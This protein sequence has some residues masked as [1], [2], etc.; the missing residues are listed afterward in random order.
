M[1][2]KENKTAIRSKLAIKENLLS[3][4]ANNEKI[5]DISITELAELSKVSRTTFYR[6]YNN[7]MDVA[8]DIENDVIKTVADIWDSAKLEENALETFLLNFNEEMKKNEEFISK[9]VKNSPHLIYTSFKKNLYQDVDKITIVNPNINKEKE[10]HIII[11]I[12]GITSLYLDYFG[13]K[14]KL[15]LDEIKDYSLSLIKNIG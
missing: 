11:L 9:V 3:L 7:V 8:K 15:S 1:S 13:K 2:K 12:S 5:T 10:T 6:H 4:L 14:S